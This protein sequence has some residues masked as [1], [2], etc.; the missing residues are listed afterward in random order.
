MSQLDLRSRVFYLI[1]LHDVELAESF[2]RRCPPVS[3]LVELNT[4]FHNLLAQ[5]PEG[6]RDLREHLD[7]TMH[8]DVWMQHFEQYILPTLRR[9]RLP[10]LTAK[11]VPDYYQ[12]SSPS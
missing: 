7:D 10:P 9:K 12:S 3:D 5:Y 8:E 4:F 11:V 2:V 1:R 6:C